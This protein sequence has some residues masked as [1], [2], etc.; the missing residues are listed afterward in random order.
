MVPS[1]HVE[2]AR[3]LANQPY[4]QGFRGDRLR[5]C[6]AGR[7][8]RLRVLGYDRHFLR[9]NIVR[10]CCPNVTVGE[11]VSSSLTEKEIGV[12]DDQRRERVRVARDEG[13]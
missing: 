6:L 4:P 8:V 9:W 13:G 11:M 7:S 3:S 1:G 10:S 5:A 2:P 12:M